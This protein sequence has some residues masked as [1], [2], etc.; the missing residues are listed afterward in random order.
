M[1]SFENLEI[2]RI[3]EGRT[4]Y[5]KDNILK[6][7]PFNRCIGIFKKKKKKKF[8]LF[9]YIIYETVL[10]LLVSKEWFPF[11]NMDPQSSAYTINVSMDE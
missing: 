7:D 8:V 5:H 4:M 2:T 6:K 10:V 11:L 1:H 3:R 9:G